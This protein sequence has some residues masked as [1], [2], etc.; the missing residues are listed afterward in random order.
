MLFPSPEVF[1]PKGA[2]DFGEIIEILYILNL[3]CSHNNNRNGDCF[4]K[5]LTC[6][7]HWTKHFMIS[8]RSSLRDRYF[9]LCFIN[10]K[11]R[12]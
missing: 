1:I 12:C 7:T 11:L 5:P 10:E 4:F 2:I 3:I 6:N 9:Y 8:F